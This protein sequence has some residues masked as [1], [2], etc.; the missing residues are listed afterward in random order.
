MK[1][2]VM[3]VAEVQAFLEREFPQMA[4][5][6][7]VEEVGP[8]RARVRT[9]PGERH[10]RPGGTV[11]G[12]T[13]F[14]LADCAMYLCLMAMIGPEALAVTTNASID[15]CASPRPGGRWWRRSSC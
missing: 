1:E 6:Y 14:S 12:P 3:G 4:G 13:L 10:L 2:P 7:V 9:V 8:M 11:S 15:S 5:E